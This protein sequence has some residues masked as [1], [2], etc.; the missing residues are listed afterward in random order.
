MKAGG[1][2]GN[3]VGLEAAAEVGGVG[4]GSEDAGEG[5][6]VGEGVVGHH[7]A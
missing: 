1:F 4:R 2:D 7:G 3:G 6:G 5:V